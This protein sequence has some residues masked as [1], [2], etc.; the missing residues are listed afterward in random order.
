M[1]SQIHG[2]CVDLDGTGVL[3]RGPSGSGK[4]DLALRLVDRGARLVADDRVVITAA[5]DGVMASAPPR[6][7]G[8]LEVRGLGIVRL[9][10]VERSRIGLVVDLA[11]PGAGERLPESASCEVL[12]VRLRNLRLDPFAVSTVAKLRLAVE[13]LKHDILVEP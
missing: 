12:G 6:L 9:P 5:G 2:T 13:T 10:S 7:A 8:L 11:G 3:L 4:S 1:A